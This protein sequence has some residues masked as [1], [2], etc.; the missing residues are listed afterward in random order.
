MMEEPGILVKVHSVEFDKDGFVLSSKTR[1]KVETEENFP[2]EEP[3]T[4]VQKAETFLSNFD[5]SIG[6]PLP[7]ENIK[8]V[9]DRCIR[10]LLPTVDGTD[11][12]CVTAGEAGIWSSDIFAAIQEQEEAFGER[13]DGKFQL[14]DR[15]YWEGMTRLTDSDYDAAL[16]QDMPTF[17]TQWGS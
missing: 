1:T 5:W 14:L 2:K 8:V 17:R 3:K 13:K 9:S 6:D 10:L 4:E 7:K 12:V 15:I 11:Q 16:Y